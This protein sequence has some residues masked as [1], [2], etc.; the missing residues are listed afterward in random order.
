MSTHIQKYR[1]ADSQSVRIEDFISAMA[2][3]ASSV[4][5]VAT[6]GSAGRYGQTVSSFCSVSAEPPQMLICLRG[7]S[8]ACE[9]IAA[10]GHFTIN[11][12]P[13]H[14]EDIADVFAGRPKVGPAYSF[15]RDDW[16]DDPSG[17]PTA[18]DATA[19]FSCAVER[20]VEAGTHIVFIG[21]V[22][23]IRRSASW[24]LVYCA[25]GYGRYEQSLP[26]APRS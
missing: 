21:R 23:G 5:I 7:E 4:S 25:R 1:S 19:S 18:R 14:R 15:R 22:L 11:V 24:P 2:Y 20:S 9:A 3:I 26:L 8:P 17:C 16:E 12:L 10:N 13:E 6:D